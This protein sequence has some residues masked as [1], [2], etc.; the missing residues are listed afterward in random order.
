MVDHEKEISGQN[1]SVTRITGVTAPAVFR[2]QGWLMED[3]IALA[4]GKC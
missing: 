1:E 3:V 2:F 4:G